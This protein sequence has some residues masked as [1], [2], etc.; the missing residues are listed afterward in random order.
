MVAFLNCVCV[1]VVENI[2]YKPILGPYHGPGAHVPTCRRSR[3]ALG[4][5]AS[6]GCRPDH[7]YCHRY[8]A[9]QEVR[10]TDPLYPLYFFSHFIW[11]CFHIFSLIISISLSVHLFF[12]VSTCS[13]I[14]LPFL[15]SVCAVW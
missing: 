1:C 15:P 6:A 14:S 7:H 10:H 2:R 9:L 3:D 13:S 11:L 12:I 8:P 5:G 4:D